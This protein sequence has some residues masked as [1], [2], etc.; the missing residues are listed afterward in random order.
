MLSAMAEVWP[1]TEINNALRPAVAKLEKS[2]A[3]YGVSVFT[4]ISQATR[5]LL[6]PAPALGWNFKGCFTDSARLGL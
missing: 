4:A 2:V 3:E 5:Q 6:A 1:P